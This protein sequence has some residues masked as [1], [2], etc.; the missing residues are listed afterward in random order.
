[1]AEIAP[2][3]EVHREGVRGA[4]FVVHA[5]VHGVRTGVTGQA[6]GESLR[7]SSGRSRG[8]ENVAV[9]IL[10]GSIRNA[11]NAGRARSNCR[12]LLAPSVG[13]RSGETERTAGIEGCEQIRAEA[14]IDDSETTTDYSL[15]VVSE[16]RP[17]EA[18]LET[19]RPRKGDARSKVLL[20]PVVKA[21]SIVRGTSKAEAKAARVCG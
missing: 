15:V 3:G 1:M 18:R 6:V 19:R 10:L 17:A 16:Q 7:E 13:Q 20:V 4:Q 21:R 11:Q 14:V 8:K 5:P 2:D 12:I 9:Q